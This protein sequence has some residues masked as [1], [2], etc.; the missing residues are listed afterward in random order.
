MTSATGSRRAWWW[1]T[2]NLPGATARLWIVQQ[3]P[4]SLL[5]DDECH[6]QSRGS[7]LC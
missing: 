7:G 1:L 6:G 5:N 4:R 2:R 3:P